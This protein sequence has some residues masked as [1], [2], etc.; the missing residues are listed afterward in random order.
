MK[1]YEHLEE[2]RYK[3]TYIGRSAE[4]GMTILSGSMDFV[5]SSQNIPYQL[6]GK[7][8]TLGFFIILIGG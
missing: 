7:L 2:N 8:V 5:F 1:K 4:D 3:A 6:T